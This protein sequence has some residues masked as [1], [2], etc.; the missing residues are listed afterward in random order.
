[1]DKKTK[2]RLSKYAAELTAMINRIR[3]IEDDV[4]G[5]AYDEREK[6][7]NAPESLQFSD[8]YTEME[9]I[10]DDLETLEETFYN[11]TTAIDE[12]IDAF[13]SITQ[14]DES[15]EAKIDEIKEL[16]KE[17]IKLKEQ[18]TSADKASLKDKTKEAK[19]KLYDLDKGENAML[20]FI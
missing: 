1:M 20:K 7:E 9:Q 12:I 2:K 16:E 19:K 3:E 5:M 14:E 17:A 8:K 4:E 11:A 10:A 18:L 13:N 15:I 6:Y